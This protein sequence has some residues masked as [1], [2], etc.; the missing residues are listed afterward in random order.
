MLGDTHKYHK[1]V[2]LQTMPVKLKSRNIRINAPRDVVFQA[3]LALVTGNLLGGEPVKVRSRTANTVVS[4]LKS[5]GGFRV[6]DSVHEFTFE[7]PGHVTFT[8]LEGPL[9]SDR[10][11][12]TLREVEGATAL[13]FRGE[14]TWSTVPIL[15]WLIGSINIA[16]IYN[17]VIA[18]HLLHVQ[19]VAEVR[20]GHQT[21]S[22][23]AP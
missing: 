9:H 18:R 17:A 12:I 8:Q 21:P 11:E 16:S 6:Y 7:P 20:A 5:K 10:G 22:P 15:G 14:F 1:S 23:P 13:E 3:I 4:E 19:A 2:E